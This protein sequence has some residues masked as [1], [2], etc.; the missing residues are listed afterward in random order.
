MVGRWPWSRIE[1]RV[2]GNRTFGGTRDEGRGLLRRTF[3]RLSRSAHAFEI[4]RRVQ[5]KRAASGS[6]RWQ[7]DRN[8]DRHLADPP[9][10]A[11]M[12]FTCGGGSS[13]VLQQRVER[14]CRTTLCTSSM[15]V[16]LVARRDGRNGPRPAGFAHVGDAGCGSR[17]EFQ[18]VRMA[19]WPMI[20]SQWVAR[21]VG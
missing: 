1:S 18:H 7:R 5:R 10:L 8:R 15:H 6:N 17:V 13:S 2:R 14:G 20:A 4:G 11:K 19:G 9:W 3:R 12:N 21:R 16:D